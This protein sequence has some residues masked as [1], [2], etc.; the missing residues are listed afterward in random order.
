MPK[1]FIYRYDFRR[2]LIA[3]CCDNGHYKAALLGGSKESSKSSITLASSWPLW[4][5]LSKII[6]P[7]KRYR[8][9]GAIFTVVWGLYG[10][11]LSSLPAYAQTLSVRAD[12]VT[13][14]TI[15][16][17]RDCS[18]DCI[19]T[20][21][22]RSGSNLFHSFG[23]FSLADG[24]TATFEDE[25]A[26]NIFA[27]VSDEISIVNGRLAV[28]GPGSANLFL[29]N[30]H[31]II[32]GSNVAL[33]IAG[34]FVAS[35]A[36]SVIFSDGL[37]FGIRNISEPLLTISTPIG[38]PVGLQFGS[39]PGEIVSYSQARLS[40]V[41]SFFPEPAGRPGGLAV[42]AGQTL[43]LVGS[44]INLAGGSLIAKSG[45]IELGSVAADSL[46]SVS[47]NLHMGYENVSEFAD[48]QLTQSAQIDVSGNRGFVSIHG[49]NLLLADD[50]LISNQIVGTELPG[51]IELI[52]DETIELDSSAIYFFRT[53]GTSGEGVALDVAANRLVLKNGS[54]LLG[55][56]LSGLGD[57]GNITI[58]ALDSVALFGASRETTNYITA[59]SNSA[60]AGGDITINTQR[61][62]VSDGSQIESVSGNTGEGGD[63]VINATNSV[64]VRGQ[65]PISTAPAARRLL[66]FVG[67]DF[68]PAAT[69]PSVSR[70]SATSGL[71]EVDS[72]QSMSKGGSLTVNTGVL[73]ISDRAQVTVGSFG[74]G[75]SG[76]LNINARS[77]RLDSGAQLSAAANLANGGN[78]RLAGLE[79]LILRRGSSLSTSAGVGDGGNIWIDADFVIAQAFEDSDIVA[80]ATGGRSGNIIVDTFGVYGIAPRRAIANNGTSD[81]DASS[82]FG[83][84]GT[85]AITQVP[86]AMALGRPLLTAQPLDVST[87]VTHQCGASGNSFVVSARGGVPIAPASAV[88]MNSPLVDLG[89][90]AVDLGSRGSRAT[91]AIDS[92]HLEESSTPA[93]AVSTEVETVM[94]ETVTNSPN[95]VEARSW[96][97]DEGGKVVLSAQPERSSDVSLATPGYCAG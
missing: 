33:S 6:K 81:I 19:I 63:I 8:K 86:S 55:A 20:G 40:G 68:E 57:A 87:T 11:W 35:T 46:V 74:R 52:A 61:L 42:S 69:G 24:V 60:G 53:L 96:Y 29:L 83:V 92:E 44:R 72:A 27:N 78:L 89:D 28:R 4:A 48:V 95:W 97:T 14:T 70:I 37:Q 76:D 45:R 3:C 66:T 22:S 54:L 1:G 36:E 38:A 80:K 47:S 31:G 73:S 90:E 50:S 88:A 71:A 16:G 7:K 41:P 9:K 49:R 65:A 34:S 26:T 77:V 30:Q 43:A 39:H 25:G 85:T 21:D 79:T 5:R 2:K 64:E 67:L 56:T 13:D 91:S 93:N 75:D 17:S 12:G 18:A 82:E 32:F 23:K 10:A 84:S 59:S 94:A 51:S 15:I 62:W 58:S